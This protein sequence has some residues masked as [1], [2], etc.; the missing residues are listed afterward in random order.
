MSIID[1]EV[2]V[3]LRSPS[4]FPLLRNPPSSSF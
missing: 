2:D 1:I 3:L 4:P